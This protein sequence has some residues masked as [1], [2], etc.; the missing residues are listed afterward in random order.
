MSPITG[1]L[2]ARE[3]R[4]YAP[5][6]H[7]SPIEAAEA[8][9]AWLTEFGCS[10][11]AILHAIGDLT[12]YRL[13]STTTIRQIATAAFDLLDGEEDL[14]VPLKEFDR[15][16]V[17]F[18]GGSSKRLCDASTRA[19][20]AL[21][22][23]L[24]LLPELQHRGFLTIKTAGKPLVKQ[25]SPPSTG[26]FEDRLRALLCTIKPREV[27]SA[28]IRGFVE[29]HQIEVPHRNAIAAALITLGV[30]KKS[31]GMGRGH[32]G[33]IY[34]LGEWQE[35]LSDAPTLE[36]HG[37][38]T[39][40]LTKDGVD[41]ALSVRDWFSSTNVT[42]A[43]LAAN[44]TEHYLKGII[45]HLSRKA[46]RS[47]EFNEIGELVHTYLANLINRDGL[48][49][50]LEKGSHPSPSDIKGWVYNGAL[51]QWRDEGKDALTRTLKGCRTEREVKDI[52][53]GVETTDIAS[54]SLPTD[55]R[56]LIEGEDGQGIYAS[57]S[58]GAS[59]LLDVADGSGE[60][61]IIQ[62]LACVE[63]ITKVEGLIKQTVGEGV[64]G[65]R[66]LRV[67]RLGLRGADVRDVAKAE[68]LSRNRA[69]LVVNQV[70]GMAM[71]AAEVLGVR[72]PQ[73]APKPVLTY[74]SEDAPEDSASLAPEHLQLLTYVFNEPHATLGDMQDDVDPDISA[75]TVQMLL[76]SGFLLCHDNGGRGNKPQPATFTVSDKGITLAERA[77]TT[78]H[79]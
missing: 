63:T 14:A 5:Q 32:S 6:A 66:Y 41:L 24:H 68:G 33:A 77:G 51:S 74:H 60:D 18:E 23:V 73:A 50:R 37:A 27:S 29:K 31:K 56:V 3:F 15:R 36:N 64:K 47:V 35:S 42:A 58:N 43:W 20:H 53:D 72:E 59:A 21:P 76:S 40:V 17:L 4:A 67:F 54:R 26:S 55:N 13:S 44:V 38:D 49:S 78:F 16:T 12:V 45:T 1:S 69:S 52:K 7:L 46:K 10:H 61:E 19:E 65:D 79:A 71:D 57:S 48:R 2:I 75:T 34:L 11:A 62:R 39:V 70:R 22:Q 28:D 9:I 25:A 8:R 30:Q